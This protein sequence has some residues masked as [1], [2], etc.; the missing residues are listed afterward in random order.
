MATCR[1]VVNTA[2]RKI[3]RL[4]AGRE[5]R[6]ADRAE[7]F[8]ALVGLYRGLVDC[9]AFG[10]PH[11]VWATHDVTVT[12]GV[13]IVRENGAAVTLPEYLSRFVVPLP[14]GAL[15]PAAVQGANIDSRTPAHTSIVQIVDRDSGEDTTYMYDGTR[16]TWVSLDGLQLDHE[17]P[18]S[19]DAEGLGAM[20]AVEIADTFSAEVGAASIS[21]SA[22][23]TAANV[24]KG[25]FERRSAPGVYF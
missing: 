25:G 5:P 1:H 14:Y 18:L 6:E 12:E 22:R 17:A 16:Q 11:S 4:G 19:R 3:G 15:W 20:L 7:V 13:R 8:A 23:W 2:L 9:G 10:R 21:Q 24:T